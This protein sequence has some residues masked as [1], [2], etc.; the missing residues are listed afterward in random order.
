MYYH[1]V[2]YPTNNTYPLPFGLLYQKLEIY[3][4]LFHLLKTVYL[5]ANPPPLH[6]EKIPFFINFVL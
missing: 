2:V 3:Y 6:F 4:P 5:L 1:K